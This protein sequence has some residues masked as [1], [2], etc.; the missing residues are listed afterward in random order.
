MYFSV[1]VEELA[2][3]KGT[4]VQQSD[5]TNH[6]IRLL[7][8]ER[9]MLFGLLYENQRV[10]ARLKTAF[11][12]LSSVLSTQ[13]PQNKGGVLEAVQS[14][15]DA[16]SILGLAELNLST[17]KSLQNR[18]LGE[19]ENRPKELKITGKVLADTSKLQLDTPAEEGLRQV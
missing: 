13:D 1:I 6:H 3:C 7:L 11:D 15:Y 8:H 16:I 14:E 10:L 2:R 18:L 19:N 12:P 5:D 9:Q 17:G 4:L